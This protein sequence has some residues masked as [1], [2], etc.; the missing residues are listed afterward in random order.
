VV[1]ADRGISE[2]GTIQ[3]D[4]GDFARICIHDRHVH[5]GGFSPQVEQAPTPACHFACGKFPD[6]DIDRGPRPSAV[7]LDRAALQHEIDQRWH[8]G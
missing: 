6:G 3:A 8:I 5:R 7:V 2:I 4:R 1:Q